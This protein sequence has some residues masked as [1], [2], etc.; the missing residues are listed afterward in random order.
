MAR[1]VGISKRIREARVAADM[2][3]TQLAD[4]ANLSKGFMSDVESSRRNI[5]VESLQRIAEALHVP[6]HWL[7]VGGKKTTID[8]PTCEGT[9]KLTFG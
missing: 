7:V 9:G 8:C 5:S 4:K 2:T 1:I 6:I 3:L